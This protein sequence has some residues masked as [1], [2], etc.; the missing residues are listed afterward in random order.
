MIARTVNP[1]IIHFSRREK[2]C[3]GHGGHLRKSQSELRPSLMPG[4]SI[5]SGFFQMPPVLHGNI[6]DA[7]DDHR[8]QDQR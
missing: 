2:T 1:A 4:N 7:H 6:H 3:G 5:W 8:E